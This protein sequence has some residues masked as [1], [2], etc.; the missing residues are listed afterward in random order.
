MQLVDTH[1]H[2][3]EIVEQGNSQDGVHQKWR[4]AD[5]DDA[6]AVICAARQAGVGQLLCVGTDVDDSAL[7]VKFVEG[8]GDAWATVGIHPHEAKRYVGNDTEL[9]RLTAL[10]KDS[11]VVGI[12]ECGLDYYY[13]HSP[14]E[15]QAKILRYQIELALAKD[16]PMTFHVRDAFDD[17]WPIFDAY[18]ASAPVR[19]VLHSFSADRTVLAQALERGLYIALNGIM[20]FTKDAEQLAAAREVPSNR[21]LLETDAPYLTPA[22]WR[23]TICE[24]KHVR[25]TLEFLAALREEEAHTLA[26]TTTTNA[27]QLFRLP[28]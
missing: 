15:D 22:P 13:G 21:L 4:K 6:K 24:P 11:K 19:G 27:R 3:H 5:V 14:K 16:L 23:G 17:F 20:T 2:I 26:A 18:H 28:G 8:R 7:A 12:G 10:A 9:Q 1:C 25:V